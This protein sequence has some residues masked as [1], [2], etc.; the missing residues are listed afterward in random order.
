MPLRRRTTAQNWW[1]RGMVA[2]KYTTNSCDRKSWQIAREQTEPVWTSSAVRKLFI[3]RTSDFGRGSSPIGNDNDSKSPKGP[4]ATTITASIFVG[5]VAF[6]C[7]VWLAV[8]LVKRR[9]R[10]VGQEHAVHAAK[11]IGLSR[12]LVPE[13]H[14]GHITE[15]PPLHGTSELDGGLVAELPP[16][17]GTSELDGGFIAELPHRPDEPPLQGR[18]E[19]DGCTNHGS[20]W[21]LIS[22]FSL[23]PDDPLF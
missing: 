3:E 2:S 14:N 16:L 21:F 17:H 23:L 22:D 12:K 4:K 7:L 6:V 13:L 9:R 20:F 10:S 1:N 5:V 11:N 18:Y 19:L 8:W 15:L